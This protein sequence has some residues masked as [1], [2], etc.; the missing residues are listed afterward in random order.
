[1]AGRLIG[2]VIGVNIARQC[3]AIAEKI[4]VLTFNVAKAAGGEDWQYR[5]QSDQNYG[6]SFYH[7]LHLGGGTLGPSGDV[8]R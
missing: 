4:D 3:L 5:C 7:S 2:Q 1:M 6:Q 8:L